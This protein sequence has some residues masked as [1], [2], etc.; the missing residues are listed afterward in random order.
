MGLVGC[1]GGELQARDSD[2]YSCLHY[3]LEDGRSEVP[4]A[5]A[6]AAGAEAAA[7]TAAL[8]RAAAEVGAWRSESAT[9][10]GSAAAL[11]LFR[12]PVGGARIS[13]R[14]GTVTFNR[15]STVRAG[16]WCPAG[17]RGYCEVEV[18]F[19]GDVPQWGFCTADW[20]RRGGCPR[21]VGDEAGS[22]GVDGVRAC[23]WRAGRRANLDI[24]WAG[25]DV[26]GLAC[27]PATGEIRAAV[28]GVWAGDGGVAVRA[29]T[30]LAGLMPAL[31]C[32]G[33]RLR[34]NLGGSPFRHPPPAGY[35][36]FFLMGLPPKTSEGSRDDRATE[37][38]GGGGGAE[39]ADPSGEAA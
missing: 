24:R 1:W 11:E 38:V 31:S 7:G 39:E 35:D 3:A 13:S 15:F 21:G 10:G 20:P 28:N 2:G 36:A 30:G 26:I 19:A 12:G 9:R 18:V 5:L 34:V 22:W 23:A 8:S 16:R 29:G 14:S 27:D 17:R 32:S 25:G 4:S 33:S 6:A 37:S